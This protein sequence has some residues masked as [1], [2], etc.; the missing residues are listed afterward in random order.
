M[1][2]SIRVAPAIRPEGVARRSFSITELRSSVRVSEVIISKDLARASTRALRGPMKF[3][4]MQE[5][6]VKCFIPVGDD[7]Y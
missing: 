4:R 1:A 5:L 2:P 7:L 6:D 3:C